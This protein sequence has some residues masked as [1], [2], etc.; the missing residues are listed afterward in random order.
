M[1][2]ASLASLRANAARLQDVAGDKRAA[3]AELV[4][5]IDAELAARQSLKSPKPARAAAPA[6]K[7]KVVVE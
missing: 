6:R 1:D 7:K 3:A 5:L 2:D 4:P